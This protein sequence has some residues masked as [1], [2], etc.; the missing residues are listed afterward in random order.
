MQ[1]LTNESHPSYIF[2]TS[3]SW[4]HRPSLN[5]ARSSPCYQSIIDLTEFNDED[6]GVGNITKQPVGLEK[7][8]NTQLIQNSQCSR[9]VYLGKRTLNQHL[10]TW[11][12]YTVS[13]PRAYETD[14][15]SYSDLNPTDCVIPGRIVTDRLHYTREYLSQHRTRRCDLDEKGRPRQ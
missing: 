7:P 4:M 2:F 5:H 3:S 10:H 13:T 12:R 11:K 8:R 15:V 1:K 6:T 14:N 9:R